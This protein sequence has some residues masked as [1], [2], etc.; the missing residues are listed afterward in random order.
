MTAE[1]RDTPDLPGIGSS[2]TER[3]RWVEF[4]SGRDTLKDFYGLIQEK[5]GYEGS[6]ESVRGYHRGRGSNG[7]GREPPAAYFAVLAQVFGLSLEW[8]IT[9]EGDPRPAKPVERQAQER[10][11]WRGNHGDTTMYA[12]PAIIE[13]DREE[14]RRMFGTS[15]VF[16]MLVGIKPSTAIQI[17]ELAYKRERS[18]GGLASELLT[19]AVEGGE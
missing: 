19:T 7:E 8:L 13:E 10:E 17:Q 5:G 11:A 4:I 1:N 9:G 12:P 18:I 2:T 6:Y 14:L 16:Y 3:L 15:P